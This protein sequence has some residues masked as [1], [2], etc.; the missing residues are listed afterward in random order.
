MTEKEKMLAGKL[1]YAGDEELAGDR[2]TAK[3]LCMRYNTLEPDDWNGKE[4]VLKALLG[5]MG[6]S[7]Y[8]EPPI[9]ID[10]GWNLRVGENF[11]S[12]YNLVVLD[13]GT[14]TIGNDVM[15]GPNVGIYAAGHPID[16]ET[17]N[18]LLEY[19]KPITIEDSVWIGGGVT[20]NAG[21]TIGAG[22]VIAS[23][24]VVTKDIPSGVLAGG[25]PCRVIRPITEADRVRDLAML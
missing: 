21:V 6:K 9:H 11:Y 1:Y 3:K 15:I 8:L 12:N 2:I 20:I 23:G 19:G 24:S 25:V 17:R 16:A 7:A 18:T 13:C 14:V 5:A 22:S 10:Y 4:K